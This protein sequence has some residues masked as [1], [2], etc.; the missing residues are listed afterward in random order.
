MEYISY[1]LS[2]PVGIH[3]GEQNL[4]ENRYRICADTLFSA[5]YIEALKE[6][7]ETAEWLLNEAKSGRI[8]LSDMFP[9][10]G[11]TAYLP[12]PMKRPEISE[13]QGSST[14]KKAFKKLGYVPM[15][16]IGTY[17]DGQLDATAENEKL[18]GLGKGSV[19]TSAAVKDDDDAL[20]YHVGVYRFFENAGLYFILAMD[21]GTKDEK[22]ERLIRLL[23]FSGI[24][25]KRSSGLGRFEIRGKKSLNS[26]FFE[27]N[28]K[29]YMSLGISLPRED[30]LEPVLTDAQYAIVK[31]GGFVQSESY[32]D[33]QRKKKDIYL[34]SAGSCFSRKFEGDIYDVSHGGRHPVYRYAKPVFWAL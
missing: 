22:M 26:S 18:K 9:Y 6:S 23:S 11:E 28:R 24:G 16:K 33:E 17:L 21:D 31:R 30:E 15:D 7:G 10:I 1:Y 2:F 5:L 27:E 32:A 29:V 12:K 3:V 20:P 19:K 25:G 34:L 13:N 8:L 4:D 14:V